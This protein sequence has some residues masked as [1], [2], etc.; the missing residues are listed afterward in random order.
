MPERCNR[1]SASHRPVCTVGLMLALVPALA[2]LAA[3]ATS[4]PI[5][6]LDG[7]R[8]SKAELDTYDTQ[9]ISVDGKSYAY[10]SRIRVDP[11]RHHIV[12]TAK[13][14]AGFSLSK[15]KALDL[16]VEPCMRYWFEAKR[17]NALEQ[18]FEP[19]VNYKEPIAGCDIA[20]NSG[21]Q[22]DPG[23]KMGGY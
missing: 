14:P 15:E 13:P 2:G 17:L 10:N 3:C 1:S 8:W 21:G 18:D 4:E 20:S 12:F 19:R 5:S 6:D 9:I 23:K 16:D 22:V 7:Y 11:G